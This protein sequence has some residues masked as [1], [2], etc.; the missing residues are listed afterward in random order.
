MNALD[1]LIGSLQSQPFTWCV[2][3]GAGFIGSHLVAALLRAGQ[4]VTVLDNFSTGKRDNLDFQGEEFSRGDLTIIDGDITDRRVVQDCVS[5]SDIVLH[6]AALGSVPRSMKDP[7]ASHKANA[8]GFLTVLEESRKADVSSFVYA[9]SSSV[10]GDDENDPKIENQTGN[11]LS[12][13]AATKA[14]NELYAGTYA[15]AYSFSTIG[16]RYFNVFGPRQDPEGPYAAVIPL[17]IN[18]FLTGSTPYIYGDGLTS[19]DFCYVDNVVLAN[20]KAAL[21][22]DLTGSHVLNISAGGNTTL[23]ELFS[24]LRGL[25][26][27]KGIEIVS[28]EPQYKSFRPGDIQHSRASVEKAEELVDYEVLYTVSEGLQKTLEWYITRMKRNS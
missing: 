2:T 24:I 27:K 5:G 8:T 22:F 1:T 16:L 21:K 18:Q 23:N 6:Q 13:Y 17:W 7:L 3:G 12:P 4:R 11:V 20:L 28:S 26:Q 15:K 10:Y 25:C 9:S 19:R 14:V